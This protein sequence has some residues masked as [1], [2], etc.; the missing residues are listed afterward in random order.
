MRAGT[1]QEVIAIYRS[2]ITKNEYGEEVTEW[3]QIATTRA[4]LDH[5]SQ[6]TRELQ[7]N[8]VTY[9]YTKTLTVRIYVDVQEFDR[10]KW[11]GQYYRILDIT[12]NKKLQQK[13]IKIELI[14]E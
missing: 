2:T 6:N 11:N 3:K 10:I 7:N 12:P 1:L 4:K 14:N 13:E 5:T 9:I 8:E